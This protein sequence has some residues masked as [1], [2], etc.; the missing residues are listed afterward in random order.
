M[1]L[2]KKVIKEI[3]DFFDWWHF[4]GEAAQKREEAYHREMLK[5]LERGDMELYY[6]LYRERYES[7]FK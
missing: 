4:W 2:L 5:A 1:K 7:F 3:K 6:T